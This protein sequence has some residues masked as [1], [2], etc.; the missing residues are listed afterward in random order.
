MSTNRDDRH[1]SHTHTHT[2]MTKLLRRFEVLLVPPLSPLP[3]FR[4]M[5]EFEIGRLR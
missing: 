4:V 1:V 5:D 2:D 3:G